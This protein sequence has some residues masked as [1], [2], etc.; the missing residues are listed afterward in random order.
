MTDN[1]SLPSP[2][3]LVAL[4]L[5]VLLI[6]ILVMR[7]LSRRKGDYLTREDAGASDAEDADE[8]VTQSETGAQ[9]QKMRE[10]FI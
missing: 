1:L 4:L 9:V 10:F 6:S 7:R 2:G 3:V 5:L 8:A